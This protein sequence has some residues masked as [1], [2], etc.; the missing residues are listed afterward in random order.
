MYAPRAATS[1]LLSAM[2]L[3]ASCAKKASDD[4]AA[5]GGSSSAKA[6]R[7]A[8]GGPGARG[9]ASS[10]ASTSHETTEA[11]RV[12]ELGREPFGVDRLS[13]RDRRG[14]GHLSLHLRDGVPVRAERVSPAGEV[15]ASF[16]YARTR[17]GAL[18]IRERDAYGEEA[19]VS[20]LDA[21]GTFTRTSRA[22]V[23]GEMGCHHRDF[24]FDARGRPSKKTCRDGDGAVVPDAGGCEVRAFEWDDEGHETSE[25]CESAD[26]KPAT[27][28]GA[29]HVERY[30]RDALGYLVETRSFEISGARTV[31]LDGC[32]SVAFEHDEHGSRARA[33][34]RDLA[35]AI[36]WDQ[37]FAHDER[38]CRLE[39]SWL[40]RLGK[41][42][43]R[44]GVARTTWT[45]DRH[46]G[47]T[48]IEQ[49]GADGA[50]V[51]FLPKRAWVFDAHGLATEERCFDAKGAPASCTSGRGP[52]GALVKFEYDE[53][54]RI[55]SRRGFL[56]DGAPSKMSADYPHERRS[57]YGP[58]GRLAR[59]AYFDG[60]GHAAL[61]LGLA[62]IRFAYDSLGAEIH[63]RFYDVAGA[64]VASTLGCHEER[65]EYDEHHRLASKACLGVDGKPA[66]ARACQG[67]ICWKGAARVRVVRAGG[68]VVNVFEEPDG[69]E[70]RRVSCDDAPC[71]R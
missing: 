44:R 55:R 16:A 9:E 28:I 54:G 29:Q 18:E 37:R 69:K 46:C 31:D 40:D 35:D 65:T 26:G 43:A 36:V 1:L 14:R 15:M 22:G 34:C 32:A 62:E 49:R 6:K 24:A 67:A 52:D 20:V 45:R 53:R 48:S 50:L 66:R 7:S 13:E 51:A 2:L 11:F 8:D 10:A 3:A 27:F 41:P 71:Y 68:K 58:D 63:R 56:S 19:S 38:G 39:E 59:D 23:V 60:A 12:V 4:E 21:R 33:L 64:Q 5:L 57:A 47:P 17:D 30:R 25:R 70:A 42:L 61:A